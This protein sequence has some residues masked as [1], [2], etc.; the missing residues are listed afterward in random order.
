MFWKKVLKTWVNT[1]S[2]IS[3]THNPVD[4]KQILKEPLFCN[5]LINYKGNTLFYKK[6]IQQGIMYINDIYTIKA[7]KNVNTVKELI[8]NDP[9]VYFEYNIVINSIP[10]E[11]KRKISSENTTSIHEAVKLEARELCTTTN[12]F[13][14]LPNKQ[15]RR[16]LLPPIEIF[17]IYGRSFWL[18]RMN[19]DILKQF[20]IA[21]TS[22]KESRLRLLHFKILHNIYPTNIMLYRM[23]EAESENCANCKEK[24]YIEHMFYECKLLDGFWNHV[25]QYIQLQTDF[26]G[27]IQEK[28]VLFGLE[29]RTDMNMKDWRIINSIILI[30]KM[31][32]SKYRYRKGINN[33]FLIFEIEM[34]L[35]QK[36]LV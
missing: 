36:F 31:C 12:D 32:I 13:L 10:K 1:N 4:L 19:I 2:I 16:K 29:R 30:A 14:K 17:P 28:D 5:E 22:T 3:P 23:R 27:K 33:V 21:K 24:D 18:R 15:I 26:R 9:N 20:E 34:K 6:W 35:R 25:A 7:L 8:Q 11:W